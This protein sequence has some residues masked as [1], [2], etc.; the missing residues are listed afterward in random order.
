MAALRRDRPDLH[1]I[2]TVVTRE[3]EKFARQRVSRPD[4]VAWFPFDA[5]SCV[6]RAFDAFTPEFIVLCEVELWPNHL[7]EA[8]SRGIPVIVVNGRLTEKDEKDYRRGGSFIRRVFALPGLVCARTEADAARFVRLGAQRV[9]VTGEMKFDPLPCSTVDGGMNFPG[10]SQILLGASTHPGEETVLLDVFRNCRG[11]F[12]NLVL[13]LV[14]RHPSRAAALR[15]E[16]AHLGL[17]PV[18][19][20][21]VVDTVGQLPSLFKQSTLAFV[22]KSLTAKGGQ[23]FLEAVEA[24]CPVIFGPHMENFSESAGTFVAADAVRQVQD[25]VELGR[26]VLALLRAPALRSGLAHRAS[27]LLETQKGAT[28]RNAA[29]IIQHLPPNRQTRGIYDPLIA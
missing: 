23:N 17:H 19:E 21:M 7:R 11:E 27:A 18:T 3:G 26:A 5:P 15:E 13:V 2:L 22:G 12:P 4:R 20:C 8:R 24:G 6:R 25:P 14:P 28:E 9:I 10:H 29:L 16:V 1:F